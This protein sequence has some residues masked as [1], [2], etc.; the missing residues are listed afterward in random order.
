MENIITLSWKSFHVDLDKVN[1]SLKEILSSNYNGLVCDENG[2][3][4]TFASDPSEEDSAATNAYWDAATEETFQPTALE[5]AT[6][7]LQQR[8]DW[9]QNVIRQFRIY[10]LGITD[11]QGMQ[12]LGN[13]MDVKMS[14]ELG[15][16]TAAAYLLGSKD[17]D[18]ILD[19]AFD[20]TRTVRERF[21]QMIMTEGPT[22]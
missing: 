21:I 15:M 17:P 19:A 20:E 2:L 6:F 8:M 3:N 16:L 14:L 4:V 12:M 10:S 5:L 1:K 7:A 13:L 11:E 18:S 22:P 9:G